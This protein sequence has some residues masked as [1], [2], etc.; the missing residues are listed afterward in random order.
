MG[1]RSK[2]NSAIVDL[3]RA[4]SVSTRGS[5]HVPSLLAH[6]YKFAASEMRKRRF[7]LFPGL[8]IVTNMVVSMLT[9]TRT[10]TATATVPKTLTLKPQITLNLLPGAGKR[11]EGCRA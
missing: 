4:I 11:N 5:A 1:Y 2:W 6:P 3:G 9:M 7:L 10:L 8:S